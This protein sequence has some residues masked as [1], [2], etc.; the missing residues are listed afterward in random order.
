[1]HACP[2]TPSRVNLPL[3]TAAP[4]TA[5][6]GDTHD[7]ICLGLVENGFSLVDSFVSWRLL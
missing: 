5:R 4:T 1:M 6:P 2:T 3:I 7:T